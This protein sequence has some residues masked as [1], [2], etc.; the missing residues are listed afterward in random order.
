MKIIAKSEYEFKWTSIWVGNFESHDELQA[1]AEAVL[2]PEVGGEEG[3]DFE[4]L[5]EWTTVGSPRAVADLIKGDFMWTTYDIV[6]VVSA[7]DALDVGK[8]NGYILFNHT[9]CTAGPH[10]FPGFTF[11]GT[12]PCRPNPEMEDAE[13]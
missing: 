11:L 1:R 10:D 2:M 12:F 6:P 5:A 13:G 4:S 9:S 8:I 3:Y 7:A